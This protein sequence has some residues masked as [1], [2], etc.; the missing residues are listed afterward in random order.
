MTVGLRLTKA[1]APFAEASG[2]RYISKRGTFVRKETHGFSEFLLM[3]YPT[4]VDGA[5]GQHY[6][7]AAGVRHDVVEQVVNQLGLVYGSEYQSATTTVLT[8]PDR[9]PLTPGNQ[10]TWFLPNAASERDVQDVAGAVASCL[11]AELLS[12]FARYASL[13]ECSTGLN[14][15]PESRSHPLYNKPEPRMYRAITAAHLCG[16]ANFGTLVEG[17]LKAYP[18]TVPS[19]EQANVRDRLPRLLSILGVFLTPKSE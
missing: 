5:L 14:S 2:F 11:T 17:W 13:Q 1:I 8:S 7:L 16:E 9:F 19:N 15:S 10:Y 12:Y 18:M 4:V 3:T 6:E